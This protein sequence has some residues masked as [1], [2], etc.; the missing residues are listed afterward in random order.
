M[1]RTEATVRSMLAAIKAPFYD[2]GVL[3]DRGVCCPAST[4]SPPR[5]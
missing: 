3:S 1:D 2:V 4:L 5:P